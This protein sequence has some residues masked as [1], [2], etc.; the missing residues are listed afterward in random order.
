MLVLKHPVIDLIRGNP[1]EFINCNFLLT[2]VWYIL[3][4]WEN[5]SCI[6]LV[7]HD[8]NELRITLPIIMRFKVNKSNSGILA[9][10]IATINHFS[11]KLN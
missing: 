1:N 6:M 10:Q 7:T 4:K 11:S 2:A 5:L 8:C 3:G 9:I